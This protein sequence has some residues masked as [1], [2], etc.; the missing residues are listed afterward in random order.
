MDSAH[1]K[2][3]QFYKSWLRNKKSNRL[4]RNG[5]PWTERL[6]IIISDFAP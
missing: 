4:R 3:D 2:I 5:S 1:K 6:R